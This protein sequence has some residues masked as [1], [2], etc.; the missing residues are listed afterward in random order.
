MITPPKP[1]EGLRPILIS[2]REVRIIITS[3]SLGLESGEFSDQLDSMGEGLPSTLDEG[4][5]KSKPLPKSTATHPKDSRGNKQPLDRDI[6]SM[7]PDEG[8]AKTMPRPEG[9]LGDKDSR[10]NIPHA[11]MEPI[12]TPVADPSGTSKTSSEVEP[13][14]KP[15]Q[16]HTFTNIQAFLLFEDELEKE[17]DEEDVLAAGDDMDEDPQDDAEVRTPSPAQ[18]QHEPSH[19]QESA[20]YSSSLD[21]KKFDNT[22]LLIERK[23][24]K[25]LRKMF[26]ASIKE[27]YEEN[28]A[29]RD[30]TDQLV[31][32]SMSFKLL[33]DINNAVK[34]DPSTNKKIDEAIKMFAK[35]STQTTK[36][37]SLVK[38]FDFSTLQSTMQNL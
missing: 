29:H 16:L 4:T 23:L 31:A 1:T 12:H 20:S 38:T 25:Y 17:S 36:I 14:T 9:S 33:K 18:T 32:A 37:L 7:I 11:D 21:L 24:I 10:G 3:R 30:Q 19:V 6:T 34:D 5:R 28:I 8:T 15:L 22:L 35:I 27:Y 26:R 2:L 13:D